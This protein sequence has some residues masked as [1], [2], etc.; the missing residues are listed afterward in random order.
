MSRFAICQAPLRTPYYVEQRGPFRYADEQAVKVDRA[1][2][3]D[4]TV[5]TGG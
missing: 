3:P 2:T 5:A 1:V 4:A